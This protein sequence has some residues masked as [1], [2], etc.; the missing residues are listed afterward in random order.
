MSLYNFSTESL[1]KENLL[2]ISKRMAN[3]ADNNTRVFQCGDMYDKCSN[4]LLLPFLEE[5]TWPR[6]L[7]AFLYL[8]GLLYC[9]FGVAIIADIFMG[10]I[11]KITSKTRKVSR[12]ILGLLV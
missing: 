2:K 9:F 10:A 12:L 1:V 11:E 3:N 5:C 6:E 8:A 7:R 4:G